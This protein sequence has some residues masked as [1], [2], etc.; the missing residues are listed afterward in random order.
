MESGNEILQ[1]T[2]IVS[3]PAWY[4]IQTQPKHEHVAAAHLK[5]IENVEVFA[6][7]IRFRRVTSKG[8]QWVVQSL[9]PNYLLAR[10]DRASLSVR[11][12]YCAG[13]ACVVHFGRLF[14]EIPD[15]VVEDLINHL[16]TQNI[17]EVPNDPLPEQEVEIIDGP[18]RGFSAL[19]KRVYPEKMRIRVLMDFLGRVAE[20]DVGYNDIIT[21]SSP[22]VLA[23]N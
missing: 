19:V 21:P 6:P 20:V 5:L 10:F 9:F 7:R 16:G 8:A 17:F 23:L 13:V 15:Q 1:S 4:C 14:P 18:F 22:R 11:I 2:P 12:Q 3:D